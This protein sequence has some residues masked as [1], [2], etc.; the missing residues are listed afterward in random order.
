[1]AP[2]FLGGGIDS[3]LLADLIAQHQA[4][5]APEELHPTGAVILVKVD[6][7]VVTL[8]VCHDQYRMTPRPRITRAELAVLLRNAE[9]DLA[10]APPYLGPPELRLVKKCVRWQVLAMRP[11]HDLLAVIDQMRRA[12]GWLNTQGQ[13][14]YYLTWPPGTVLD[15]SRRYRRQE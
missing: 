12:Q 6:G 2:P 11:H 15:T 9:C 13:A 14:L 8:E 4:K 7:R 5:I 1:M 10:P 3:R